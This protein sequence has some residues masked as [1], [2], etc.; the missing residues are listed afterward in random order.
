M[1]WN[2]QLGLP[3]RCYWEIFTIFVVAVTKIVNVGLFGL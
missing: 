2:P 3:S 1:G